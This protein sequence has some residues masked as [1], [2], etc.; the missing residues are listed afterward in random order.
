M[1]AFNRSSIN[2]FYHSRIT[3]LNR[4]AINTTDD[5]ITSSTLNNQTTSRISNRRD[6]Y[7]RYYSAIDFKKKF[8]LNNLSA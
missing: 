6:F 4:S 1:S 7:L 2:S 5:P 8:N 3:Y